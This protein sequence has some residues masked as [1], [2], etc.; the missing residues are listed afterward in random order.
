M[1]KLLRFPTEIA[2]SPERA[3]W[4]KVRRSIEVF[5]QSGIDSTL[6][7][8]SDLLETNDPVLRISSMHRESLENMWE[9]NPLEDLPVEWV[10]LPYGMLRV[11]ET[12]LVE[13]TYLSMITEAGVTRRITSEE[14]LGGQVILGVK[15]GVIHEFSDRN[16][17]GQVLYRKVAPE[18]IPNEADWGDTNMVEGKLYEFF[19][20]R[21]ARSG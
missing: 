20:T 10:K 12:L 11:E 17:S 16:D 21:P 9:K 14:R 8:L 13:Q 2:Q 3:E 4:R 1:E 6:R 7:N 5:H 18:W 15:L 19:H